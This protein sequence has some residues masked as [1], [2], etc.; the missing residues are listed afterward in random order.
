[1]A[2]R[3]LCSWYCTKPI[4][5]GPAGYGVGEGLGETLTKDDSSSWGAQPPKT[6][7][8]SATHNNTLPI[9]FNGFD[10]V[11]PQGVAGNRKPPGPFHPKGPAG[12]FH[13]RSF[14]EKFRCLWVH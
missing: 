2:S 3:A 11:S 14:R 13:T 12:T 8:T 10:L 5:Q 6:P 9:F 7:K 4:R 1:M